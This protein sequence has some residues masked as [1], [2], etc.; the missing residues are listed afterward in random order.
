MH[1]DAGRAGVAGG[2]DV[3]HAFGGSDAPLQRIG[4]EALYC[5]RTGPRITGT[6]LDQ[7]FFDVGKLANL[8]LGDRLQPEHQQQGADHHGQYRTLDIQ[9][10]KSHA[11]A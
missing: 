8:E 5:A 1:V 6:H 7:G 11:V 10:S 2:S 9:V 4:D 3:F